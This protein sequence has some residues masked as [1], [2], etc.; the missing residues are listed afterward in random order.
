MSKVAAPRSALA[1]A[2][3]LVGDRWSL[4]LVEALMDG[5]RRFAELQEAVPGIATNVLTSR[6][7]Q[8]EADGVVLASAYS[9][10][11]PRYAYDLTEAGHGL[12][13]AVR[14]LAQWSSERAGGT[15]DTPAHQ[16]CGTPMVARWWCPTCEQLGEPGTSE[17]IWI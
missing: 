10:R 13:G 16:A 9:I 15:V 2:L 6:L 12:G 5:P 17:P 1:G 3:S 4:L 11:P 8:M 14:L 7:R